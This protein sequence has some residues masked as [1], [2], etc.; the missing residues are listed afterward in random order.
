[1]S[2]R[3]NRINDQIAAVAADIIR[4]EMSDP[5]IGTVVSVTKAE[6][7]R[8]LKYCKIFVSPL[9]DEAQINDTMEALKNAAGFVRKRLA[10]TINLRVT[11][12]VKFILDDSLAHGV[13]MRKL[14]DEAMSTVE[15]RESGTDE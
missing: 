2:Q 7:T 12:E 9:G 5:R 1:M 8:D 14:I 3:I 10:E 13:R 15:N 4:T 11:P 6:T